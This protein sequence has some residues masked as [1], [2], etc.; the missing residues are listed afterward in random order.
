[1]H[2][3]LL[4]YAGAVPK[5]FTINCN[6]CTK[7]P[8]RFQPTNASWWS[9]SH[10]SKLSTSELAPSSIL[11]ISSSLR[12]GKNCSLSSSVTLSV[13]Y[14]SQ[15]CHFHCVVCFEKLQPYCFHC[16][17]NS[18]IYYIAFPTQQQSFEVIQL[19]SHQCVGMEIL[20]LCKSSDVYLNQVIRS[21]LLHQEK[22]LSY[23]VLT[24]YQQ[25]Y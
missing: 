8:E 17:K 5:T 7:Q 25:I 9:F 11:S 22:M 23:L 21:V 2:Y 24:K 15:Q 14:S 1:M 18:I 16:S 6:I 20:V 13:S 10:I 4:L 3:L 19:S 12:S